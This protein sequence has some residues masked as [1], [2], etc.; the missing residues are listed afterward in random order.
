MMG[1]RIYETRKAGL[2]TYFPEQ[3]FSYV[4]V[5]SLLVDEARSQDGRHLDAVWYVQLSGC[6]WQ[7]G[8]NVDTQDLGGSNIHRTSS[9][10]N[11]IYYH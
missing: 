11:S 4:S 10:S 7:Q 8:T 6:G 3:Y 1:S 5:G 2:R 9:A